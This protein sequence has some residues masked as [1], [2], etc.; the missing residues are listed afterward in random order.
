MF[1]MV[2]VLGHLAE[3]HYENYLKERKIEFTKA[4]TDKYYDYMVQGERVQVKRW[5]TENTDE[6]T[7][8]VNL[9]KTHGDRKGEGN[10][11][12]N[13][14]FDVL[15][16]YDVGF[17]RFEKIKMTHIPPNKK[18]EKRLPGAFKIHR[19]KKMN[20]DELRFLDALKKKNENF[21]PEIERLR[22]KYKM[23]YS[24]FVEKITNLTL[25]QIDSVFNDDN[26]RLIAG[27]KGFVAEEHFNKLLDQKKIKYEQSKNMYDK[28]DHMV[29]KKRIQVK[30]PYMK[31]TTETKLA[32]KT[33]KTHGTGIYALYEAGDFD[34]IALFV[35]Y[36]YESD[37]RY[38]PVSTKTEF[39]FISVN[40]LDRHHGYPCYLKAV[41][42]IN[43]K[44]HKVNDVTLLL[45]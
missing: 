38:I 44:D 40:N 2:N 33:H 21:T 12:V 35:G 13:S 16:V 8:S 31:G 43:R 3:L 22:K 26:F 39:V 34:I 29:N 32:F 41:N 27:A 19:T 30:T 6:Q 23:T 7:I 24:K 9:T 11:Y 28:T 37:S 25:E 1:G 5:C 14:A 20:Q 4:E 45:D 15:V 42:K 17:L 18:Y 36:K 10:Y